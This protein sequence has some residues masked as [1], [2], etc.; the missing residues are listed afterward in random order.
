MT[1]EDL[2]PVGSVLIVSAASFGLGAIYGNLPYDY[3]TLWKYDEGAFERSLAHYV[4]W[5][6]A[7]MRVHHIM[8]F[9]IFLGLAGCFI[10]LFKPRPDAKYFEYATLGLLMVGVVIYL[11]NLRIGI[12]SA[13]AG[14]WGEVD[15]ATGIS[16]VAASQFMI[17]VALVGVMI[18]QGG[19]Y[20]AEVIERRLHQEFYAKEKELEAAAAAE[21]EKTEKLEKT[22][23]TTGETTGAKV[24]KS[25]R[26]KA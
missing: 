14:D 11:T 16:V 1:Y 15:A 12:N 21:A 2:V 18:L 8:H 9:V 13:L 17:V 4:A 5:A 22:E 3:F 23:K 6:N 26:K 19:M 7:P 10:K 25:G 24:R 20:Y